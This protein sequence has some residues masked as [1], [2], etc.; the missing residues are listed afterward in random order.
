[1]AMV[2]SLACR[3]A[4]A[5]AIAAAAALLWCLPAQTAEK[6]LIWNFSKASDTDYTARV[7]ANIPARW[8]LRAGADL[9]VRGP[10]PVAMR[11]PVA[12]WSVVD[13]PGVAEDG[14]KVKRRIDL[15]L[16]GADGTRSV[17]YTGSRAV[18]L[19]P[20][21]SMEFDHVYGLDD[22]PNASRRIRTRIVHE[23]ELSSKARRTKIFARAAK[24]DED[25]RWNASVG[26]EQP[27]RDGIRLRAGIT[28]ARHPATSGFLRA[29]YAHKW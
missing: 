12:L 16:T 3:A 6:P 24:A 4:S 23:L 14:R 20:D 17:S 18:D 26:V 21:I 9:H 25:W 5:A 1:M 13:L 28:D 15:R 29:S 11:R 22:R 7:G 27:V 2:N 8:G 19:G 10:D